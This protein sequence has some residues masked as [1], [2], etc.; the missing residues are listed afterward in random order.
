[1]PRPNSWFESNEFNKARSAAKTRG[2]KLW[3]YDRPTRDGNSA[4][5]FV[6]QQL[7]IRLATAKVELKKI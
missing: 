7:P 6:G 4:G 2:H 1:M 3:K 5:Y